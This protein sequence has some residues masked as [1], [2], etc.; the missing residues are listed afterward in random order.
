[1]AW[2]FGIGCGRTKA[3]KVYQ[4]TVLIEMGA[5]MAIL[6]GVM[7]YVNSD[8]PHG[9]VLF[10]LAALPSVPIVG[11]LVAIGRYLRDETDEYQRDVTVRCLLLGTGA[12][13]AISAFLSF[14]QSVGWRGHVP[15]FLEFISFFV[16]MA[17]ARAYYS[18]AD[19]VKSDE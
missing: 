1:M 2:G 7:S 10:A 15:P 9:W 16:V 8:H 4:R 18:F 14:L 13:L 6:A 11:V 17:L 12:V 3:A 19:R 5:Y